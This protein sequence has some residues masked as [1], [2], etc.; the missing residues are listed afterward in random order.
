MQRELNVLNKQLSYCV[1]THI[2]KVLIA[3]CNTIDSLLKAL[4]W[5]FNIHQQTELH[6]IVTLYQMQIQFI[7]VIDPTQQSYLCFYITPTATMRIWRGTMNFKVNN[8]HCRI[9]EIVQIMMIL[10]SY[11]ES[12]KSDLLLLYAIIIKFAYFN[13]VITITVLWH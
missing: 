10:K 8:E 6:S 1:I 12:T 11:N 7:L 13:Q 9:S 4:K 2:S 5:W 3:F